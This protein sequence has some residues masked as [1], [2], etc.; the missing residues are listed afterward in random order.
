M[1][2]C[3]LDTLAVGSSVA[4]TV[5]SNV[6]RACSTVVLDNTAFVGNGNV[7]PRL[8][9]AASPALRHGDADADADARNPDANANAGGTNTD[10]DT[11]TDPASNPRTADHFKCYTLPFTGTGFNQS[12]T[13]SDQFLTANFM[14]GLSTSATQC[15]D[16]TDPTPPCIKNPDDH[17]KLQA[18]SPTQRLPRS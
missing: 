3:F 10:A 16:Q 17:L 12:I 5:R 18:L 11:F 8:T 4:V 6:E 7:V 13:V 15:K 1:L 2:N 9:R 14:A